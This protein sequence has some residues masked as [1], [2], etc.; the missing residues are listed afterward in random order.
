MPNERDEVELRGFDSYEDDVLLNKSHQPKANKTEELLEGFLQK[1][2]D[3]MIQ[4]QKIVEGLVRSND[5]LREDLAV[6]IGKMER[7][8][9]K[10]DEFVTII[11]EAAKEDTEE[12]IAKEV[13]KESIIPLKET[14]E[15]ISDDLRQSNETIA[16]L[17]TS[18][19]KRLKRLS[20]SSSS[21]VEV[22]NIKDKMMEILNKNAQT[23]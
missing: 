23:Q 7:L 19:D 10:F 14:L 18:I 5:A 13:V 8:Y 4:N 1:F 17:L 12:N 2:I 15:K 21:S 22:G 11:K 20:S 6:M 9:D 16:D 3:I